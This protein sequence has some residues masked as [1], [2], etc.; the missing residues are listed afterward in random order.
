MPP[1]RPHRRSPA[2]FAALAVLLA[3]SLHFY[4][5]QNYAGQIGGPM[6][7]AKL[8]WLDYA[9]AAW[10]IVPFFFWRSARIAPALRHIYAAHL[11]LFSLRAAVELWMLYLTISWKPPYGIAHDLLVI[12]VITA[13]LSRTTED[14]AARAD[15]PNRAAR[16]FLL[17]IRLGLCCEILFAWLFYRAIDGATA[18]Y[19]ASPDPAFALI[20]R[21][22]WGAVFF[23]PD[24][25]F[26]LWQGRDAL[27][28]PGG[29]ET[30]PRTW[31][32]SSSDLKCSRPPCSRPR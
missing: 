20:N 18:V 2:L 16:R 6:S 9:L 15:A 24:L 12:V 30:E 1:T 7:L 22:T 32:R 25:A 26:T 17:S 11:A 4:Y 5:R 3:V 23:Y 19:F 31:K 21:L 13:L 28:P 29:G 27:F 10:F 8:L 14:Q